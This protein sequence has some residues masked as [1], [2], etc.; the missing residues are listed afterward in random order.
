[1]AIG[2]IPVTR[3]LCGGCIAS[4]RG[5]QGCLWCLRRRRCRRRRPT[6]TFGTLARGHASRLLPNNFVVAPPCSFA[7]HPSRCRLERPS[8][9]GERGVVVSHGGRSTPGG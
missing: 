2:H 4:E 6:H 9:S 1:M 5:C 8:I 7:N 3:C